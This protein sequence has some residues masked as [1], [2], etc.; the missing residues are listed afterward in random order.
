MG[1]KKERLEKIEQEIVA[2]KVRYLYL[3]EELSDARKEL[4]YYRHKTKW[5]GGYALAKQGET[6]FSGSNDARRLLE[7]AA[8]EIKRTFYKCEE[9]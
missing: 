8:E 6:L 5:P 7:F 9:D 3:S 1:K 2:L 4:T